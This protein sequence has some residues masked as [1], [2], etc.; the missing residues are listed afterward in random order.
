MQ[1][2]GEDQRQMQVKDNREGRREQRAKS[3]ERIPYR[4][5]ESR[6]RRAL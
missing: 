6:P 5:I 4:K 2:Q 1:D 3:S